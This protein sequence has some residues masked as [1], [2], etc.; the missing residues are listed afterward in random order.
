MEWR[1]GAFRISDR[2]DELDIDLVHAF[3]R[4]AYWSRDVSR[5][6]LEA[7][8][9]NSLSFGLYADPGQ[10]GFG[11]AVTDRATFAYL[12][13]VFVL[14]G[15]RGRGL[16]KWL[17]ACILEHPELQGLRRWM[18]ATRDAHGLYAPAGFVPLRHPERFMEISVAGFAPEGCPGP[19]PPPE[20]R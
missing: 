18:L 16:G 17:V 7:A 13:D 15:Y 10:V 6:V 19:Q 12:S 1:R 9:A 11:R 4:E 20:S 14:P 3:L 5:S 2:Q 8:I